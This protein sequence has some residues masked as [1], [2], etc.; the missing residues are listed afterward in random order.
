[1]AKKF[2]SQI[3]L[4]KIPVLGLVPES[5]AGAS[6]PA[7][8]AE[9]QLWFDTTADRLKVYENA[10]WVLASQ[11]G[12]ELTANKG[13]ASGY[14][15]LDGST[16][17]PIA[18]IPTGSSGTTVALGNH[19][20]A[21]TDANI[22]GI[23]PIAQI[24]TGTSGTTVA[25]GNDSR[26]TDSRNPTGSAGGS[27]TGT[28]P[29]PTI[30]ALAITDAMVAAANKDGVVGTAS[31]RTIGTGAQQAMAGN[32]RLDTIAAPT[33]PVSLNSQKIT[34]L[35]TPTLDNDAASKQY[36][37]LMRQGIRLKDSVKVATTANI[38][39]SGTQTI[40]GIA[41][42]ALDRV[43][44]KTQTSAQDNGIYV[45]AAGAWARADDA[46]TAAE[47]Q[48]G[49]TV[50]VQQGTAGANSSWA[51]INTITTLG[52]DTQSWVQ[53]GASTS[54][55][56][57]NGLTLTGSTFDVN[58]D[59]SSIEISADALRVKAA[60]ITNAMLAGSIDLTTKVTGV[61]PIANGGTNSAT[62]A[63]ARTNLGA[64]GKYAATLGALTAG[65]EAT[66][67]HS[68]GTSDVVA[69]FR[70][71]G[72]GYDELMSWRVIDAN[73]IGLTTDIA[74]SASAIRVVVVG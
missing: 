46:S 37:D 21:L 61:L 66:I 5:S 42:V 58:V 67:T 74:Y 12:A 56:G 36:V 26:F 23:L 11:T 19:G 47:V 40:D 18:Q 57:G 51:Q 60:G 49:A 28:Y 50:F 24:P 9:G 70:A 54:Y 68:L 3:D 7:S 6:P 62:A 48:D 35:A 73:S 63:G 1:M 2:G 20:H 55:L 45:V 34:N 32:T 43:L 38:T 14:A 25:L 10:A 39:L 71:V 64:T 30:A 17:V 53:Q 41:V 31:M 69:S 33:G 44:V 65:S 29:N 72:T 16:K 4:Q 8:P 52:T 13:A 15:S 59:G 22:T 27:L